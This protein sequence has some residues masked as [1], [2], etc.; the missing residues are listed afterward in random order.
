MA[1][2]VA[3]MHESRRVPVI[4]HLVR[5][6]TSQRAGFVPVVRNAPPARSSEGSEGQKKISE[7][8]RRLLPL[9]LRPADVVGA[10]HRVVGTRGLSH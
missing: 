3:F 7:A 1:A 6:K 9:P 10:T 8:L 5:L 2:D 4:W